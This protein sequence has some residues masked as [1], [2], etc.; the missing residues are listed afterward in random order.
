MLTAQPCATASYWCMNSWIWWKRRRVTRVHFIAH[1][2]IPYAYAERLGCIN[3]TSVNI[4]E[5]CRP[6]TLRS[7]ESNF[8]WKTNDALQNADVY[9]LC[10]LTCHVRKVTYR[11]THTLVLSISR[12]T[13][14]FWGHLPLTRRISKISRM[15][16]RSAPDRCY[17]S[18]TTFW[19]VDSQEN[20]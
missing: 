15:S 7:L 20:S 8:C 6:A 18:S 1:D 17:N 4:K 10:R 9:S 11:V 13:P 14:A 19:S 12:E 16:V 2:S 3:C 5:C